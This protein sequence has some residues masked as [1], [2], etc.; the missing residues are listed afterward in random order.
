MESSS[1]YVV[2]EF[3]R[4]SQRSL[5]RK[6]LKCL[7]HCSNI[8]CDISVWVQFKYWGLYTVGGGP[9]RMVVVD[10]Y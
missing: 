10:I 3:L 6:L 9:A 7:G 2:G 5:A 4:G 1:E 8:L